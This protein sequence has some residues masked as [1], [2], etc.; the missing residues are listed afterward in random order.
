M[1]RDYKEQEF[2]LLWTDPRLDKIVKR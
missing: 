1:G 2:A